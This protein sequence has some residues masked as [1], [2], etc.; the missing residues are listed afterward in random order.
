METHTCAFK[1]LNDDLL[2]QLNKYKE[3]NNQLI[4]KIHNQRKYTT[5]VI[6][7]YENQIEALKNNYEKKLDEADNEF[8]QY[9]RKNQKKIESILIKEEIQTEKNKKKK[10]KKKLKNKI[11]KN[12][13]EQYKEEIKCLT[14][15][16][17]QDHIH[18]QSML[19]YTESL[20]S[21]ARLKYLLK[22]LDLMK[23][24]IDICNPL[25][26]SISKM[27]IFY[28]FEMPIHITKCIDFLE[29][30]GNLQKDIKIEKNHNGVFIISLPVIM[31]NSAIDDNTIKNCILKQYHLI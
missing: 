8:Y 24:N 25:H 31:K 3:L 16:R 6:V 23:K 18:Y 26:E 29:F 22:K 15:L 13:I 10:N 19:M 28:D 27:A 1:T 11:T 12:N 20:E 2:F 9:K 4:E 17:E 21:E 5:Q 30:I 7:E 14:Y